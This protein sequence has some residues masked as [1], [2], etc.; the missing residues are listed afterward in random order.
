MVLPI[1]MLNKIK[2]QK[3]VIDRF[4]AKRPCISGI[5]AEG[6]KI[7]AEGGYFLLRGE[8]FLLR[9]DDFLLKGEGFLLRGRIFHWAPKINAMSDS[10]ETLHGDL[11]GH[12]QQN[13]NEKNMLLMDFKQRR[14]CISG[15]FAKGREFSA[16]GGIITAEGVWFFAEGDDFLLRGEDIPLRGKIFRW[17]PK[18]DAMYDSQTTLYG[19]PHG[20]V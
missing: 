17:A 2:M 18:M 5:S 11:H 8:D 15:I 20:H 9:G 1:D 6:R 19:D 16:E 14:P 13:R 7:F 3:H 4:Q 12:A 10:H